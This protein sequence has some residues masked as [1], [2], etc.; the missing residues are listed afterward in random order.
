MNQ[1]PNIQ[2]VPKVRLDLLS[3]SFSQKLCLS[4]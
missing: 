3:K 4:I 2:G 1:G